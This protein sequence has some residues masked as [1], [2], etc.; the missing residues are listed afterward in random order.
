MPIGFT[1]A[2]DLFCTTNM[3]GQQ[4]KPSKVPV[5]ILQFS[6]FTT[7]IDRMIRESLN[8]SKTRSSFELFVIVVI[9]SRFLLKW[10]KFY[11]IRVRIREHE[12]NMELV[13]FILHWSEGDQTRTKFYWRTSQRW[14]GYRYRKV[15]TTYVREDGP[16][17][18]IRRR[19]NKINNDHH[20]ETISNLRHSLGSH[21]A[22][23]VDWRWSFLDIRFSIC[24]NDDGRKYSL[25]TFFSLLLL[26]ID[27]SSTIARV[28]NTCWIQSFQWTWIDWKKT[29]FDSLSI[30]GQEHHL[31]RYI[32]Q[33][34]LSSGMNCWEHSQ[35]PSRHSALS[36]HS[37]VGRSHTAPG[38]PRHFRS[39]EWYR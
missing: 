29:E 8:V 33:T 14:S 39:D 37:A 1:F 17:E 18:S 20:H 24:K 11:W 16:L 21:T 31:W 28:A 23:Y 25:K 9:V 22:A 36:T 5:L 2:D 15:L 3:K 34:L 26:A 7:D 6:H 4:T 12:F 19:E 38:S 35:A 13:F 32:P 30:Q 10:T 27:E